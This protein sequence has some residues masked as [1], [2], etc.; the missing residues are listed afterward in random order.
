M[1]LNWYL[2]FAPKTVLEYMV[3]HELCHLRRRKH[4]QK[5]W[6]LVGTVCLNGRQGRSASLAPF[7]NCERSI[8]S[9]MRHMLAVILNYR[10]VERVVWDVPLQIVNI[11]PHGC[12]WER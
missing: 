7:R 11:M 10:S 2:I 8:G 1:T 4:D 12:F 5:F 9:L 3:L 6:G